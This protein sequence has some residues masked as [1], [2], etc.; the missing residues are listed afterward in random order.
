MNLYSWSAFG[1]FVTVS[2]FSR[3]WLARRRGVK[4]KL[5]TPASFGARCDMSQGGS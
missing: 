3:L 2:L 5:K 4:V 1:V